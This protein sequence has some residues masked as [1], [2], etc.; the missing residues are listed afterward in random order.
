MVQLPAPA[1]AGQAAMATAAA[2]VRVFIAQS[3]LYG[4]SFKDVYS[5]H[6]ALRLI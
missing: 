3:K 2:N 6:P 1:D 4:N 5:T